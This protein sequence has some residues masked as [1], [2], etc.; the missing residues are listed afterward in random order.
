MP[1]SLHSCKRGRSQVES[2][3]GR[4]FCCLGRQSFNP[5]RG[6][7]NKPETKVALQPSLA[8][9]KSFGFSLGSSHRCFLK[10]FSSPWQWIYK[11][12]CTTG[13]RSWLCSTFVC[14]NQAIQLCRKLLGPCKAAVSSLGSCGLHLFAYQLCNGVSASICGGRP[15][16]Q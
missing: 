1:S 3:P 10:V 4:C 7:K 14:Q 9:K 13:N 8:S 12:K 11:I 5:A 2:S 6:K 15:C 16:M